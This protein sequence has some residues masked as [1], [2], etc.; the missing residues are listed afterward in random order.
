[1]IERSNIDDSAAKRESEVRSY[2]RSFP[3]VFERAQGSCLYDRDGNRYVDFFSGAGAL[4]YGHNNDRLRRALLSYIDADGITH[5]LDM[6]TTAKLAFMERFHASILAP[7]N[8]DYKMQFTGPG[9]TNAIETALKIAR[10][11]TQR[12]NV[13]AFTNG[14]HG[15]TLGALAITGNAHYRNE[16]FVD[17]S[18][19]CF[20]PFDGYLGQDVDTTSYIRKLIEDRGSGFD[21]PAAIV[22]ETIQAEGGINVSSVDWLQSLERLCREFEILLIIDDIQVGCGRTGTF[23]SF[24]RAGIKPDIVVLSKSISGYGLPMSLVLMRPELDQWKPAEETATFRGP[25][26]S[27]VTATEAIGY[28]ETD[29]FSKKIEKKGQRMERHLEALRTTHPDLGLSRR[30]CGLIHGLEI[31]DADSAQAIAKRAFSEGLVIELCG[32]KNNVLKLLPPLVIEDGELD[33][34]MGLLKKSIQSVLVDQEA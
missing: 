13:A 18:N 16:A 26:L 20:L 33:E 14:Y 22:V 27:F 10:L 17:R 19:A 2:C 4:N 3:A 24:E 11:T 7:R 34:G 32:P 9:G 15:L 8:L 5:S 29:E 25:N 31:N 21:L 1:M 23:F 12:S 6:A 28:W 30:G